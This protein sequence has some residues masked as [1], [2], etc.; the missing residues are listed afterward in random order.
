M[1]HFKLAKSMKKHTYK[2]NIVYKGNIDEVSW[3]LDSCLMPIIVRMYL[4]EELFHF[5]QRAQLN[6]VIII[7]L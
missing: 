7:T 3:N 1:D 2:L 5:I 6:I 4:Y